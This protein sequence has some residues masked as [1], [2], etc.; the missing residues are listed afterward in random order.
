MGFEK[1]LLF[2][3]D[4]SHQTVSLG[5]IPKEINKNACVITFPHLLGP[6]TNDFFLCL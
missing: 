1:I 2:W 4:Q 6:G 5:K 3:K